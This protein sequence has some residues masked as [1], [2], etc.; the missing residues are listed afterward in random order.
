MKIS[1]FDY[2]G[3]VFGF[4]YDDNLR[5]QTTCGGLLSSVLTILWITIVGIMGSSL[6]DKTHPT[7][8]Q[9]VS[10]R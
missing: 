7:L 9:E 10:Q 8:T 5:L 6:F 2:L 3:S 4:T 1:N